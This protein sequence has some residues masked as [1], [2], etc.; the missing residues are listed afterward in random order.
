MPAD[1]KVLAQFSMPLRESSKY[2]LA[3]N[4]VF[5]S[6][7]ISVRQGKKDMCTWSKLGGRRSEMISV[8]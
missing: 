8:S 5:A 6:E 2:Q 7:L 3:V 4:R 1:A